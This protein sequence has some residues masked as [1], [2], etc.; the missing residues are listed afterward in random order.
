[1]STAFLI[2]SSNL[3]SYLLVLV[4]VQHACVLPSPCFHLT[5]ECSSC[6][7]QKVVSISPSQPVRCVKVQGR[8]QQ[9]LPPETLWWWQYNW[10]GSTNRKE[11]LIG[12][13]LK[14]IL[15]LKSLWVRS[16]NVAGQKDTR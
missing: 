8:D 1:M 4:L 14:G 15:H 5:Q 6:P 13:T 9:A 11:S 16:P 12:S 2:N 10:L 3:C 7:E